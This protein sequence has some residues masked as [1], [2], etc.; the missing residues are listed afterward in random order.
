[1]TDGSHNIE[2]N[3]RESDAKALEERMRAIDN[4]L[5]HTEDLAEMLG[6]SPL[7]TK[8]RSMAGLLKSQRNDLDSEASKLRADLREP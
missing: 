5:D 1:M 4:W 8:L 7:T 6:D 2:V 3:W